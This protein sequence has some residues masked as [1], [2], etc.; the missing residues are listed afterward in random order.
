MTAKATLIDR[1]IGYFSPAAG[2]RRLQA[3]HVMA[4]Y[5]AARPSRQHKQRRE[6]G[7]GDAAVLR[8]GASLREQARHLDQNHDLA[9]GILDTLV[10]NVI[11]P[12][13]IGIEPQPR[14]TDGTIH[15]E[16][17]A[18]MLS[19]LRDW[20]RRPEVTW[21]HDWP[22]VQRLAGRTWLRDGEAFSQMLPGMIAGLD[23]GTRVPFSL[24][25]IEPDLLPMSYTSP[26]DGILAGVQRNAWGRP[27][28]YWLYKRHP[29]DLFSA[30]SIAASD[31]K[32]IPADRMLH[33]ALISR[34]G[35]ARG[36]S[37]FAPVMLRLDDIKDYEESERIAAKVAASMA[38]FIR[39]GSPELWG[40]TTDGEGAAG[41][42]DLKFVPGMVMDD[43][44]PGESIE[45]IDTK[46]PN[47]GL[48]AYRRGQLRAV[49]C[50]TQVTYSSATKDY[51]GTYSAQRQEMVEG[52]AGYGVLSAQFISQF[53][54]PVYEQVVR[55][56]IASGQLTLPR[57]VLR[58]SLD[59]ALYIPPQA[60]WID[61]DKESRAME[62][63]QRAG[64][65][66]GPEIIRRRGQNPHDVLEQEAAW[67][68]DLRRRGIVTTTDP[69]YETA[70][71]NSD[72]VDDAEESAEEQQ[73]ARR[74]A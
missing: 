68:A 17:A 70:T 30:L 50:G 2:L 55:M 44:L 19:L 32:A 59:D 73:A 74:R 33:V 43:L 29:G 65:A 16:L 5:E 3:R 31:L 13:G 64:H 20:G 27:T 61:P 25:L 69:A 11:G 10:A 39:K 46:R 51:D 36:V 60:P 35:Q 58:E 48:E 42:R 45:T 53:V 38:A 40:T 54:R 4:Y 41:Q 67:R 66:S 14:R 6:R 34:I 47:S 21:R 57:D 62:R 28:R 56:A 15:A 26:R 22:D 63:L 24:E 52:Y 72:E 23:H 37:M 8:A 49:A 12:H 7:S 71:D 9:K 18:A 1:V